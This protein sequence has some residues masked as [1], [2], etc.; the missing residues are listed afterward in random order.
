M[1][2]YE[3]SNPS[4]TTTGTTSSTSTK[5]SE[6]A[7]TERNNTEFEQIVSRYFSNLSRLV[8]H[9]ICT[10]PRL[11][12]KGQTSP[13]SCFS[14]VLTSLLFGS[15]GSGVGGSRSATSNAA[16]AFE[17]KFKMGSSSYDHTASS[18]QYQPFS[19]TFFGGSAASAAAACGVG[20][21]GVA[22]STGGAGKQRSLLSSAQSILCNR[23]ILVCLLLKFGIN[24]LADV[25]INFAS[26]L[27]IHDQATNGPFYSD[28]QV[29]SNKVD[30]YY[31][32]PNSFINATMIF[33]IDF[34]FL[35]S[36]FYDFVIYHVIFFCSIKKF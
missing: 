20:G 4:A 17:N 14:G 6:E 7:A 28:I 29:D 8:Q 33:D 34:H 25:K 27:A 36:N 16:H 3:L 15:G 12:I 10:Y 9:H 2:C 21:S 32:S 22:G 19:A 11:S 31:L 24:L 5:T 30:L 23:D 35:C 18:S 13:R 1:K 26:I